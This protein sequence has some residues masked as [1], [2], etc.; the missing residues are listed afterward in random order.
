MPGALEEQ[1]GAVL[2]RTNHA[3]GH[4]S[5]R[6]LT[7]ADVSFRRGEAILA[8]QDRIKRRTLHTRRLQHHARA[9]EP[10]APMD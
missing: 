2:E 9:A 1:V 8:E 5:R 6:G 10:H 7:P 4:E 3:R